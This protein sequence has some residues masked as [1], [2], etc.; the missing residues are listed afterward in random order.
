LLPLTCLNLPPDCKLDLDLFKEFLTYT[1]DGLLCINFFKSADRER[2]IVFN[3]L[4]GVWKELPPMI[5]RRNPMLMHILV[6]PDT[7]AFQVIVAG[8]SKAGNEDLSRITE[9]FDSSKGI[10]T[11]T[12]DILGPL[13][14]LNEFQSGVYHD[15]KLFCIGFVEENDH[16]GKESIAYDVEEGIWS[17]TWTHLL[18]FNMSSTIL[19]LVE[20]HGEV[21]LFSEREIGRS[22][23]H[24]VD[25]LEWTLANG[26]ET[27][28]TCQLITVIQRKKD[29][30]RSLEVYPEYTCI[31]YDVR[32]LC[33]VNHG[34]HADVFGRTDERTVERWP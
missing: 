10:W 3:P 20:N 7:R 33:I 21:F 32:R 34:C 17:C 31:P 22:I 26:D 24:W 23:E 16:V 15:G 14:A 12:R 13:Y 27:K 29:G 28:N 18:P 8:S 6:N 4:S 30:G 9:V 11:R 25:R 2:L 19:Q 5:H 1:K